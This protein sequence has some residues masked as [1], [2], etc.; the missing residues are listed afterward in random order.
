MILTNSTSHSWPYYVKSYL[1]CV[2]VR[3]KEQFQECSLKSLVTNACRISIYFKSF[4]RDEDSRRFSIMS[5]ASL[6]PMNQGTWRGTVKRGKKM[7]RRNS[8]NVVWRISRSVYNVLVIETNILTIPF[9][10]ILSKTLFTS[11]T[12]RFWVYSALWTL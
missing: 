5:L 3:N 1:T 6:N 11:A 7:R 9:G 4:Y 12:M 2:A 10:Y 8:D